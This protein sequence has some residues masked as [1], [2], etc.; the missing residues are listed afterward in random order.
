M[1]ELLIGASVITVLLVGRWVLVQALH[2]LVGRVETP[3]E[4]D[5]EAYCTDADMDQA[6]A[7]AADSSRRDFELWEEQIRGADR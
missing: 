3:P 7:A 4:V 1:T 5:G 6:V 2:R